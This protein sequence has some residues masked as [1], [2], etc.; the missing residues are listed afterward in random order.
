[1]K[2]KSLPPEAIRLCGELNAPKRLIEHLRLVH[3]AAARICACG[4]ERAWPELRFDWRAALIGAATHDLGKTLHP[5]ELS[6]PGNRHVDD[7]PALLQKHGL[8]AELARFAR[9]HERWQDCIEIED[10]IVAL[11]DHIWK[12]ARDEALELR[13]TERIA[14]LTGKEKWR[15]YSALDR[16]LERIAEGQWGRP[17]R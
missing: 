17:E 13:I 10:L 16:I 5:C 1:M 6:R 11:A 4:I 9:T 2:V 3:D 14:A 8:P 12:E 7:G 15:V